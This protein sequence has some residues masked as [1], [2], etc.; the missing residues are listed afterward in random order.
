MFQM[1]LKRILMAQR[2][3]PQLKSLSVLPALVVRQ[4]F[5]FGTLLFAF[6][7][8]KSCIIMQSSLEGNSCDSP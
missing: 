1:M 6:T 5:P 2:Q 4:T 3:K 7:I 8:P